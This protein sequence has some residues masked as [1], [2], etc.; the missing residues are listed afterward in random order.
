VRLEVD[1]VRQQRAQRNI[2][3]VRESPREALTCG[4]HHSSPAAMASN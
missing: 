1:P 2:V 3:L 4:I